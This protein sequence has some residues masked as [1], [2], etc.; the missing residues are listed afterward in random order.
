MTPGRPVQR[1]L[2]KSSRS[3]LLR[4]STV[5]AGWGASTR[6]RAAVYPAAATAAPCSLGHSR[7]KYA[8]ISTKIEQMFGVSVAR[9]TETPNAIRGEVTKIPEISVIRISV[10]P[11]EM[12]T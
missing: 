1:R 9:A 5:V 3:S 10:G 11:G 12:L 2:L 7:R 8:Y 6:H 4:Q